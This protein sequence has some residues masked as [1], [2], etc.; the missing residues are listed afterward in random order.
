MNSKSPLPLA[1]ALILAVASL[2]AAAQRIDLLGD[3]APSAAANYTLTI[4]PGTKYV[5]VHLGDVVEF[6]AGG[7]TFAWNF[8]NEYAWAVDLSEIA[9][10]GALD[11]PVIAYVSAFRRY[12]GR[13]DS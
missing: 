5:N 8:D 10:A 3:P 4:G 9:P 7:K 12:F 1:A 6:V 11:H 13:E 2:N